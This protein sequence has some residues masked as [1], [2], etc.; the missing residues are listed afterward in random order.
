MEWGAIM[1]A[2]RIEIV[3]TQQT[4]VHVNASTEQEAIDKAISGLGQS[5]T[6]YP[7]E[8]DT[9]KVSDIGEIIE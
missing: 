9:I 2:Y 8:I 4:F 5:W 7:P 1:S 6:P 3:E